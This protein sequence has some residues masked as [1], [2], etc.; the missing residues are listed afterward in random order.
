MDRCD[1][2]LNHHHAHT[3]DSYHTC[4]QDFEKVELVSRRGEGG[5]GIWVS[6]KG[7]VC[8]SFGL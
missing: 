1:P 8:G 5:E 4:I 2:A 6:D 7:T 3:K